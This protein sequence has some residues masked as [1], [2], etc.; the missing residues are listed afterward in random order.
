VI[1]FKIEHIYGVNDDNKKFIPWLINEM[2]NG[3]DAIP[4][5]SG[6]QKR[7]FI[8]VTDVLTAYNLV[9]QKCSS[10]PEWNEFDL[11]TNSFTEV[12]E[13]VLEIAVSL[14]KKYCKGI[15]HR[16]KF[17]S[18]PYRKNEIM[19]PELNNTNLMALGWDSKVAIK[20]G[21]K[22]ILKDN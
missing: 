15:V 7:D 10:L 16:L 6:I 18:I 12:K 8:Y 9:I 20:E 19:I 13:F 1:N 2:I 21:I 5:T 14:E 22:R 3:D 4:L 11:G 17:G